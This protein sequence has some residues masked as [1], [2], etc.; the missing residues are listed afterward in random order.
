MSAL[1]AINCGES[2]DGA[3]EVVGQPQYQIPGGNTAHAETQHLGDNLSL[4][5]LV[6]ARVPSNGIEA[7]EEKTQRKIGF[8]V[9]ESGDSLAVTLQL[10]SNVRSDLYLKLL[11][12]DGKA[13]RAW[14]TPTHSL[15]TYPGLE[16][17]R[18]RTGLAVPQLPLRDTGPEDILLREGE[19]VIVPAQ[20][21]TTLWNGTQLVPAVRARIANPGEAGRSSLR[22][23]PGGC[24][25]WVAQDGQLHSADVFA[26]RNHENMGLMVSPSVCSPV[27]LNLVRQ[28][29]GE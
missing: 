29:G 17:E 23:N 1:I 12:A 16:F 28:E 4:V 11:G 24:Q 7:V 26:V 19:P 15:E 5:T 3:S 2:E 27:E 25:G 21:M 18:P 14:I 20:G 6:F 13:F 22:L 10:N 8:Q 9:M